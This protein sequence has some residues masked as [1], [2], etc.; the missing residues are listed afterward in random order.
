MNPEAISTIKKAASLCKISK[1]AIIN[2]SFEAICKY[3]DKIFSADSEYSFT[4]NEDISF[5]PHKDMRFEE[6]DL[7]KIKVQSTYNSL[8]AET[9][10]S[11]YFGEDDLISKL[12]DTNK[13]A[14]IETCQSL[15]PGLG[16]E[17][18]IEVL[19]MLKEDFFTG[20][21]DISISKLNGHSKLMA[22]DIII[23]RAFFRK[24]EEKHHK[25]ASAIHSETIL[26]TGNGAQILTS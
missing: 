20:P 8:Q 6:N 4:V 18:I 24:S 16:N 13:R 25:T 22:G 2:S 1:E 17:D 14:V 11:I 7:I 21:E 23:L 10:F 9:A 15:C 26:I 5:K 12:I 3:S 19:K